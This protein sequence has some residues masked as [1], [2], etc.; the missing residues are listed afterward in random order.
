M[1]VKGKTLGSLVASRLVMDRVLA[2]EAKAP[3]SGSTLSCLCVCLEQGPSL[4]LLLPSHLANE[5]EARRGCPESLLQLRAHPRPAPTPV[6]A[7]GP[8]GARVPP[9]A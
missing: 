1:F 7:P 9:Q 6:S 4:S 8:S 3:S 2:R 5:A